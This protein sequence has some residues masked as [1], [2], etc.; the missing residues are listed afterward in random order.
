[1]TGEIP[2]SLIVATVNRVTPLLDLLSSLRQQTWPS[3]EVVIV[4]QNRDDRLDPVLAQFGDT[5]DIR[6][7]RTPDE[8]ASRARNIGARAARG[9]V[10]AFPDDDC[11]Y[12]PTLL[13]RVMG[14]LQESGADG[15]T[16]SVTDDRG[17]TSSG[18]W[19]PRPGP[20]DLRNEWTRSAEPSL[21][22]RRGA[23][24]AVGGFDETLGP[25]AGTPWGACEG[26]DLILRAIAK[27]FCFYY[28]PSFHVH[29]PARSPEEAGVCERARAYGRGMGRVMRKHGL[30]LRF[31]GYYWTRSFGGLVLA[32]L[33]GDSVRRRYYAATLHGRIT[34]WLAKP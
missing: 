11:R 4:D 19:D 15:V 22:I 28:E 7:L 10:L 14:Y 26:D 6:R 24:D 23:F 17:K 21:F 8:G 5:L 33:R 2:I 9:G 29:H 34:G 1:M 30:P 12:P 13:Q 25:G 3:F 20:I 16:G 31:V 32:S 27:G 18:R